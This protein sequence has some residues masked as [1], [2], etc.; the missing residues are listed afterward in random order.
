MHTLPVA[1]TGSALYTNASAV[2][3]GRHPPRVANDKQARPC[4][5]RACPISRANDWPAGE[6]AAGSVQDD[7]RRDGHQMDGRSR[8]RDMAATPAPRETAPA[9]D[10]RRLNRPCHPGEG[11]GLDARQQ[12]GVRSNS[13][14]VVG[15]RRRSGQRW[16]DHTCNDR[17]RAEAC[18][19]GSVSPAGQSL[20]RLIG[21]ARFQHGRA[22]VCRSQPVWRMAANLHRGCIG[23]QGAPRSRHRKGAH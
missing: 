13:A 3:V 11:A 2:Q 12:L 1:R 5:K 7:V 16:C 17:S 22:P 20:A 18:R 19:C 9:S 6:T 14:S 23:V 8:V 4:W 10:R 15:G 21:Q